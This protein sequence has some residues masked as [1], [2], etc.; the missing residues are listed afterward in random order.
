MSYIEEIKEQVLAI[1]VPSVV[2]R[3][4]VWFSVDPPLFLIILPQQHFG[5]LNLRNQ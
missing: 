4:S 3:R 2:V 1:M 5:V